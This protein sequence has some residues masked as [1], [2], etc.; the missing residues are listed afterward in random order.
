MHANGALVAAP[1]HNQNIG[2][3]YIYKENGQDNW[4]LT[5]EFY[6]NEMA[7]SQGQAGLS[8]GMGAKCAVMGAPKFQNSH[9]AYFFSAFTTSWSV[10]EGEVS[11]SIEGGSEFGSAVDATVDPSNSARSLA[12]VG[13]PGLDVQG[14]NAGAVFIFRI[15]P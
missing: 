15:T 9:G 3:G 14:P 7:L 5:R 13:A 4:V 12:V 6:S 2:K 10:V 8:A 11:P 1:F